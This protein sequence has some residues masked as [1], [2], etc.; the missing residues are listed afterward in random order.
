[1]INK[2][3]F[4]ILEH[5]GGIAKIKS[6]LGAYDLIHDDN[7]IQF[8]FV[9]NE[10]VNAIKVIYRYNND[11]YKV[12]FYKTLGVGFKL[13]EELDGIYCEDLISEIE[14]TINLCLTI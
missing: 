5:L 8:K 1:M 6:M 7:S 4:I 10:E 11:T 12:K 9:G 2:T 13:V 3:V 14:N